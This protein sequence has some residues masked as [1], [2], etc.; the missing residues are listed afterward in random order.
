MT[1]GILCVLKG[2]G[3]YG[4]SKGTLGTTG[5]VGGW[6]VCGQVIPMDEFNLHMTGPSRC[7][8]CTGTGLTPAASA[9]QLGS[10]PCSIVHRTPAFARKHKPGPG[11]ISPTLHRRTPWRMCPMGRSMPHAY[12]DSLLRPACAPL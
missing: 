7:H 3:G 5:L 8:I 9:P 12:H 2:V 6:K 1:Q 10:P 11:S 4:D